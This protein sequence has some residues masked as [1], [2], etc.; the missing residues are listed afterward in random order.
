MA[1]LI[2]ENKPS[3]ETPI[4]A[5]NLNHNFNELYGSNKGNFLIGIMANDFT[6]QTLSTIE[7]MP[8]DTI[9]R[10]NGNSLTISNNGIKIGAG[11]HHVLVSAQIYAYTGLKDSELIAYFYLNNGQMLTNNTRLL[12][13]FE[14]IQMPMIPL[15][16][17][18]N[19]IIYL[20][21]QTQDTLGL[22]KNYPSGT[23]L[24]VI[25]LD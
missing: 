10:S 7:T 22:I 19:D 13:N 9:Y 17:Q 16:V 5:D 18:E 23:F 12:D 3:T 25:V 8:I 15:E 6:F 24:T 2:F 21:A 11:V 14:H 1:Q 20:K 4:N